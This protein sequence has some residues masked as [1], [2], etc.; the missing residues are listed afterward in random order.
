MKGMIDFSVKQPITVAVGVLLVLLAGTITFARVP[1]QM[2]PSID[3]VVISVTTHWENASP[4]EV[5]TEIVDEQEQW[6]QG[7][8]GLVSMTSI[9]QAGRGQIRLEFRTGTDINHALAEVDQKI[10]QV[11]EYPEQV[12]QPEIEATDPDSVD[13]I[14]WVGLS[15]SDP[16]YDAMKLFDFM[17]NRIKPIFERIPGISEVGIVGAREKE[18]Q[19]HIDPI[20]MAERGITIREL[21]N[22]IQRSNRN[23]SAGSLPDGKNDIRIRVL[24]RFYDVEQAGNLVI[25][26]DAAGPVYL[27]EIAEVIETYKEPTNFVRARGHVMPFL[28]FQ[29]EPGSNLLVTM[30]ELQAKIDE[31]N[32]NGALLNTH[33]QE[34]GLNGTLELVQTYDSTKYVDQALKL[35]QSNF[36]VGG[37]LAI[38]TLLLF[39]RSLKT[40]G[41]IALA[42]PISVIGSVVILTATG[43]SINI[44]SLAGL[45]FSVGMVVDNAIVVIEN[46]FRHLEMGKDATQASLDGAQEVGG[47]VLASTATTLVVF[48]PILLL[49]ESAG[50]LFRDIV[51]AIGAAVGLS[52]FVSLLVIPACAARILHSEDTFAPPKTPGRFPGGR[53]II[54]IS[55]VF[56]RLPDQLS[57]STQYLIATWKRR[58]IVIV[59][60]TFVTLIGIATLI[61]AL[62][63]LPSGNRNVIFGMLIP[64]PGYNF[65]KLQ[66]LGKRLEEK[67][68]PSFEMSSPKFKVESVVGDPS[69]IK[70]RRT[71]VP[72]PENPEKTVIP[73]AIGHYFVVGW[74]GQVFHVAIVDDEKRVA[75]ALALFKSATAGDVAPDIFGFAFQFPLFRTG[76]RSGSAIKVDVVGDDLDVITKAAS[77]MMFGLIEKFGPYQI[78][79][80]P[81]NFLLPT[82]ESQ[83]RPRDER[84]QELGLTRED[85]GYAVQAGSDGL[86]V[87]KYQIGGEL[88]DLKVISKEAFNE[89]PV[90]ALK[91]ILIATPQGN[92]VDLA[93]VANIDRVNEAQQIKRVNRQRAVTLQLT[94]PPGMPLGTAVELVNELVNNLRKTGQLP[95]SIQIHQ[96]GSAGKLTE[97]KE[98][99]LGDGTF[100][101]TLSSSMF[102]ALVVVYLTMVVLFQSWVYPF[103]IML[104]VP[105]A[106]FG[107]FLGLAIV[108]RWSM[109]DRYLPVQNLDVLTMLGFIILIGVVVNNAILIVH[110]ALNFLTENPDLD[111]QEAICES[112]R[113]R[114]R[115]ILMSTLTSVGGML[116]L[117]LMPGSGS[118]LYRGLGS[119]VVGGLVISTVFTLYLVPVVLSIA[120]DMRKKVMGAVEAEGMNA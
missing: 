90:D 36:V 83:I 64:P 16:K 8:S 104:T 77:M 38:L 100:V 79:P 60:F 91:N 4:Q 35:V 50:Q 18:V 114:V 15:S 31:L 115:P 3:S 59:S 32:Q 7:I 103:V 112:V 109:L 81:A 96:A 71:A 94:P 14:A 97:F 1:V 107:G 51:I 119:V 75:D 57:N 68:R 19:I 47:A 72:I 46:I 88:K 55:N 17:N 89:N 82:P 29:L 74:S 66:E 53:L 62:D 117:I 116:P 20:A 61:P 13:Y 42:I 10:S 85:I 93:S 113:S 22:A 52:L 95:P 39:L 99:M 110:Q 56:E 87:G 12:N 54:K 5:E 120:F 73:P 41:I 106:T 49:Q 37:I 111:P 86:Y 118:E 101:G 78:Q 69:K 98:A 30:K 108:N 70:D 9:S 2:A 40:I 33:A 26:R 44:I 80:E 84:L 43:R 105:M 76:G 25:R 67:I 21:L 63:Y 102:L 58:I 6:L 34:L 65:E 27:R 45:A 24:G 92:V 48:L 28:N 11:P 23:F